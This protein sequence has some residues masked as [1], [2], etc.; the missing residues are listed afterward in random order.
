MQNSGYLWYCGAL[1]IVFSIGEELRTNLK[2]WIARERCGVKSC[3]M[4]AVFHSFEVRYL[5]A[6][7]GEM[8]LSR[9][10]F[11]FFWEQV[12]V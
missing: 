9:C 5:S 1:C 4:T 8:R 12:C 11:L 2:I 10:V 3:G 7:S 6:A